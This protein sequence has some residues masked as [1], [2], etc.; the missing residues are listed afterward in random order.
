MKLSLIHGKYFNS[1]EAL[2]LGYI[3]GYIREHEPTLEIN[4][5]QGC[6]D[7]DDTIV[8]GCSDS[9]IVAFSCTTPTYPHSR[10]L[11]DKIRR[12]NPKVW[13]VAGG[14]HPSADSDPTPEI[15]A[16]V[17]GEG[18]AALLEIVRGNRSPRVS[19]R[20]MSFNELPW[21]DRRL[22]KNYRNIQVAYNDT[23]TRITS[24]QSHRACPFQCKYCLDGFNKVLYPGMV[25]DVVRY[26][27]V[28]DLIS[29]IEHV[30]REYQL[31]LIKFSDPT[32][33]TSIEWVNAFCEEKLRRQV[34]IPFYPN[35][36][37]TMC[38]PEMMQAMRRAGCQ[39][40]AIG[41]ESGSPKILKQIGKG[42][43]VKS[44]KNCVAW[45][46]MAGIL[47]RGYFILGMPEETH[48]DLAL[49]EQL[50]DELDISEYGFTILCPYPG[51][52]MYSKDLF[53]HIAWENTD[54]YSNDFWATNHVTNQELKEWQRR[55]TKKFA[56]R[57]TWHNRV[58]N[59]AMDPQVAVS[60]SARC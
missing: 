33:N 30:T 54:E 11:S 46:K 3:A 9:D 7:D 50:A 39:E 38:T 27:S 34:K 16:V 24:F 8:N 15:D 2:G 5:F 28:E 35:V 42:T 37:A 40:I 20:M 12:R 53:R 23:G 13:T 36:H 29:E 4:F 18:E 31:D 51:T 57:L 44:I 48:E 22:I 21:P 26:R 43:T 55:L 10:A 58:L 47:T 41:I 32:W 25:R 6:F 49:T 45:A 59:E 19:G 60:G 52:Q 56:D 1:W 17:V 14:Y